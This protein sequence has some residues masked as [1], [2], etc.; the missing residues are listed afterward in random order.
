MKTLNI[1]LFVMILTFVGLTV[2]AQQ[3]P[4]FTHYMNNTLVVNPAYAGSREALTVTALHRSQWVNFP[5][6][7]KT[8]TLTLHSPIK[9]KHIGLGLAVFNDKIGPTNNSSVFGYYSFIMQVSE[10]SKLAL[11]LSG[12][13]NIFQA[14]LSTLNLDE[15][16]DPA[17]MYNI[18]NHVMPNFG[19][20]VYYSRERFYA[21][22]SV[23]NLLENSYAVTEQ[24]NKNTL[25]GKEKRHY[26]FIAGS[27]LR[28]TDNL[29]F[30]PTGLIKMTL[31]A[32][33][34]ADLTASFVIMKKLLVGAMFRTGDAFG[35]LVGL[36]IS[37]QLHIGYSFDY[38]YGLKTFK[39][40]QGSHEILL[41]YDFIFTNRRQIHSPRYF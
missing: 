39:Y 40:H 22:L 20:G 15:K 35:G 21:G 41:R 28:L 7:P 38:S 10:K 33:I 29:D 36:D 3:L 13:I 4:M 23:P 24:A 2:H 27:M 14:N 17:F 19:F 12:G 1:I 18:N 31:G 30:K 16:V 34:E 9:Y 26:Y 8:Q 11:G 5:G 25:I 37:E 6:S 32:P